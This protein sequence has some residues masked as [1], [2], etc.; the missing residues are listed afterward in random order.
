MYTF[1]GR[2]RYSETGEDGHLTME[3]IIDYFQDCSTFQSEDLGIG[4]WYL[5]QRKLA[6]LVN[7]W[8]IDVLR[9]PALGE[10]IVIGTSPYELR[11]FMGLRNF[12][13]ETKEGERLVNANSV[14]SLFNMETQR[15]AR[16]LPEILEKYPL[17][18]R[19]E[20]EYLPRK[21]RL[22]GPDVPAR[23]H[24]A[25]TVERIHLDTNH[26]VNNG[27]YIKMAMGALSETGADRSG[28][29]RLRIAYQKQA[30]LGD[31]ICP[32]SWQTDADTAVIS[33]NGE[34]GSPYA[35]M[36]VSRRGGKI[37]ELC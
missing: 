33:L 14:W 5:K 30:V 24:E 22:P 11:G 23:A 4:V 36:E 10:R 28:T 32:V 7:Y 37:G 6:W 16:V 17:A 12:M 13:L 19:F 26:H 18:P 31:R 3:G 20:M 2:V 29:A 27:Q 34:D 25:L 1:D 21:I 15:P 8:Q 35:V 9:C